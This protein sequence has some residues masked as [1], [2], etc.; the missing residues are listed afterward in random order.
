MSQEKKTPAF[1]WP[2][3]AQSATIQEVHAQPAK[4]LEE[5]SLNS[6]SSSVLVEE[7]PHGQMASSFSGMEIPLET[8]RAKN[9][10]F[11]HKFESIINELVFNPAWYSGD[12][13]LR[14][15]YDQ[16]KNYWKEFL[17]PGHLVKSLDNNGRK[18]IFI[19][20]DVGPA[21][22]YERGG[23]IVFQGPTSLEMILFINCRVVSETVQRFLLGD[24]SGFNIG[25]SLHHF[26]NELK[27]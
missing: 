19:G 13:W 5:G 27:E 18:I 15:V 12:G 11:N 23:D 20:T 10:F 24:G 8:L 9:V 21:L 1:V 26:V 2:L 6:P 3:G 22:V 16:D 17:P 4:D 14:G 25:E 7:L